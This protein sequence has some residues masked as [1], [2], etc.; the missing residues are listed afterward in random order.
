M[1]QALVCK[2]YFRILYDFQIPGFQ[3]AESL[4]F[5]CFALPPSPSLLSICVICTNAKC[6]HLANS[7]KKDLAPKAAHQLHPGL[8]QSPDMRGRQ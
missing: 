8:N 1:A 7:T 3:A 2:S 5:L 4:E 6:E